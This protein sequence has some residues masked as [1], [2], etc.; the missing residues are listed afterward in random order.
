M[1][2][3]TIRSDFRAQEEEI[4]HYFHLFPFHLL[5]NFHK[6]TSECWQRT[7]GTQKGS[8]FSL[9]G[10]DSKGE[11]KQTE[12]HMKLD[13][14][15]QLFCKL[16][17]TTRSQVINQKTISVPRPD[18]F[19][20]PLMKR[21][22][23]RTL[24]EELPRSV[25]AQYT[26]GDQWRNNS[27]KNERME[28]KQNQ[29][30]I[31]DGTGDKSKVRCYKEQYCI[32]TWNVRSMNQGKL[33]VVKQE[34][35]RVNVDILGI[36]EVKWT[37]MGRFNPDDHYIYYHGQKTLRRNGVAIMVN[38]RVQNAVLGCNLKNDRMILVRFQGKPFNITIIQAYSP[39]SNAE[40]AEVE[41]FYEDLQ[42]LLELTPKKDVLFIIGDWNAKVGS[43]DTPGVKGKFECGVWDEAGQRLIE[44]CQENTLVIANTLFQQHKRRLYTWTS[45]DGQHQNQ[46]DY[47]LCSQRW[48]SSIQSAKI[49][50]GADC[51]SDHELL[52]AKFRLQ[53]KKLGKTTRPFSC[54]KKR[55]EKQRRKGKIYSFECR[56]NNRIGKTRDLFKKIRDT[57]GTFHVKMGSRSNCPHLLDHQK[58]K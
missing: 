18:P 1:A 13:V 37:G 21:Q 29:Y 33:E 56:E 30:P 26:T 45:P 19:S 55:S 53:L 35:A 47:I 10:V 7:P 2:A 52:I 38:K 31:V 11:D 49:R 57:K 20:K 34:T 41:R 54:E 12:K 8:P 25:G 39:T 43:Q 15:P 36:S 40:E 24:K 58:S 48:R 44:F 46:I 17:P 51:G 3:V 6:T 32:G 14:L 22:N 4:C 23:D 50:P 9:K 5:S 42:E 16:N 28:P 27:R